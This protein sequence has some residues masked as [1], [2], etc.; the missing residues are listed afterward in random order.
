MQRLR[1]GEHLGI[2]G[3]VDGPCACRTLCTHP[4][5]RLQPVPRTLVLDAG[6]VLEHHQVRLQRAQALGVRHAGAQARV[7]RVDGADVVSA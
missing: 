3:H 7:A 2:E 6:Y 4:R 5:A 1:S